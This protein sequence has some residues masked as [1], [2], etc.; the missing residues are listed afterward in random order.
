MIFEEK[1][2]SSQRIYEGAILNVRRDKVTAVKG[3]AYREIIEHNG[4]VAMVAITDDGNIVMVEQFRY[5]CGRPVLEIPAGKIDAGETDP[6]AVAVRELREETGY[7]A[8]KVILLGK[9]NTSAAY[10]EEMISVY[11]MTGLT[12]GE[13]DLDEDEAL[14]VIEMPFGEAYDMAASGK[15]IDAKTIAALLMAKEQLGL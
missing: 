12:P 8:D 3:E 9:I 10:S 1:K 6:A 11:A 2:I 15:L 4:A 5:A 7:S 14:N 13:Q